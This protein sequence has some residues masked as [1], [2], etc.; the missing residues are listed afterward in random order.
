[1]RLPCRTRQC[2]RVRRPE[3]HE[4]DQTVVDEDAVADLHVP[5]ESLVGGEFA[6]VASSPA[7]STMSS[8]SVTCA[9]R[10]VADTDARS[11]QT[12]RMATGRPGRPWTAPATVW[13]A[14]RAVGE[15]RRATF[16]PASMRLSV[17]READGPSVH[18][19]ARE[20]H[21][22]GWGMRGTSRVAGGVPAPPRPR[23]L[24]GSTPSRVQRRAFWS[25]P[26]TSES[27]PSE[28]R[29]TVHAAASRSHRRD[30]A[31]GS[32]LGDVRRRR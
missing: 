28:A 5:A 4:P 26:E 3:G 17:S 8:P 21:G 2:T 18:D 11:P 30:D 12:P 20:G 22:I 10:E 27:K 9:V 13:R 19:L 25:S 32:Q 29:E 16:N 15:A 31:D 14:A 1:M 23:R 24:S 6:P 7:T